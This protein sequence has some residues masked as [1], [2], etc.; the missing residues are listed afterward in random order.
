[1]ANPNGV[2]M[3]VSHVSLWLPSLICAL[4]AA[5]QNLPPRRPGL[6]ELTMT[7]TIQ[8]STSQPYVSRH[9]IDAVTDTAMQTFG[10]DLIKSKCDRLDWR[11]EGN[12]R[13][14]YAGCL[15]GEQ[16][17]KVYAVAT[18]DFETSYQTKMTVTRIGKPEWPTMPPETVFNSSARWA[19]ACLPGQ[20]PG[21]MILANGQFMN[22]RDIPE[23]A[24]RLPPEAPRSNVSLPVRK[25]G[26]WEIRSS[27]HNAFLPG[28]YQKVCVNLEVD[29]AMMM[30]RSTDPAA[31]CT[32]EVEQD[33]VDYVINARCTGP[34]ATFTRAVV[35]GDFQ[36]AFTTR[37]TTRLANGERMFGLFSEMVATQEHRWLSDCHP[38]MRPG[39]AIGADGKKINGVPWVPWAKR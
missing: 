18:G 39:D 3:H 4:P 24:T 20:R 11:R 21:D 14:L 30:S 26:L 9:C 12:D 5:A 27:F 38:D 33:G 32:D 34:N 13:V 7:Q 1:M 23:V 8:S 22:I 35:S 31:K 25:A 29:R 10:G 28:Q 37:I 17:F 15:Y 36:S 16:P 2:P 6:W 19:G